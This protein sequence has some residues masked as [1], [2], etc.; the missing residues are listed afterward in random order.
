M[1]ATSI[2]RV[3]SRP[4]KVPP[5]ALGRWE[6]APLVLWVMTLGMEGLKLRL[7]RVRRPI[8]DSRRMTRQRTRVNWTSTDG[9][10][11]D[12]EKLLT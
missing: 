4:P 7:R 2:S 3:I 8:P 12:E 11:N 1:G 5:A 9:I 10:N 6:L